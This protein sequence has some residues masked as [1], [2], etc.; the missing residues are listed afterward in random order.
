[1]SRVE[2]AGHLLDERHR[3]MR[4]ERTDSLDKISGVETLDVAHVDEQV[5][6]QLTEAVDRDDVRVAQPRS[7]A[8]F[9]LEPGPEVG[10]V[11]Q[12][13]SQSLDRHDPLVLGVEGPVHLAHPTAA[14]KSIEPV[15]TEP[16][17]SHTRLTMGGVA[18]LYAR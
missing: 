10:V 7:Q 11:G 13:R 12:M 9:L 3:A 2:R 5:P 6:G 1:M 17:V 14:Q 16:V 15:R 4:C 8:G 18:R